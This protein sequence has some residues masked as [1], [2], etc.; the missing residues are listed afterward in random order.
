MG[1]QAH[2]TGTRITKCHSDD[3]SSMGNF[4]FH[5]IKYLTL[6]SPHLT[7]HFLCLKI[8][9]KV[10]SD[11]PWHE[12]HRKLCNSLWGRKPAQIL[13]S[14]LRSTKNTCT[15][16]HISLLHILTSLLTDSNSQDTRI[17]TSASSTSFLKDSSY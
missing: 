11:L 12:I 7:T 8:L 15:S 5:A 4:C 2:R 13:I 3:S 6:L 14:Q 17:H 16:F 10:T 9:T 1:T